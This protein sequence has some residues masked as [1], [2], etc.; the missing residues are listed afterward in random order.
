MNQLNVLPPWSSYLISTKWAAYEVFVFFWGVGEPVGIF[1]SQFCEAGEPVIIRKRTSPNL[2]RGQREKQICFCKPRHIL[3][4]YTNKW[5]KYGK[6]NFFLLEIWLLWACFPKKSFEQVA[7]HFFV[8]KF[9][10]K[11]LVAT[12]VIITRGISQIW[13]QIRDEIRKLKNPTIFLL[14]VR[15][16]CLNMVISE[17]TFLQIW[18][19]WCIFF[20]QKSFVWVALDFSLLPSGEN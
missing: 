10:N 5:S 17:K 12:L 19:L 2:A 20:K 7:A 13:L 8:S 1:F 6:F 18:R 3:V 11:T 15:T 14:L 4:T 16:H 9:P